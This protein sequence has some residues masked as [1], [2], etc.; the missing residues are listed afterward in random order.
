MALMIKAV[1]PVQMIAHGVSRRGRITIFD[2]TQDRAML[3]KRQV[4][5][6]R[7]ADQIDMEIGQPSEKR[8]AQRHEYRVAGDPGN[9]RMKFPVIVQKP[10]MIRHFGA[11]L[12]QDAFQ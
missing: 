7:P 8:I 10:L 9:R 11:L 2:R 3:G 4:F 1:G 6:P 5:Q 12:A